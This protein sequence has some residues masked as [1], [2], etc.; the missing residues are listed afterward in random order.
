MTG[1]SDSQQPPSVS[2]E[3]ATNEKVAQSDESS[4][5]RLPRRA[6]ARQRQLIQSLINEDLL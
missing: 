1:T 6:A 2:H 5:R 4:T 3:L